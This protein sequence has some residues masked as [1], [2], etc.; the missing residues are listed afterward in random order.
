M[1]VLKFAVGHTVDIEDAFC[2]GA[3]SSIEVR[4]LTVK[5]RNIWN[6]RLLLSNSRKLS[7]S[8]G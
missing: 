3:F 6:K 1:D 5:L 2:T 7:T 8:T 4:P